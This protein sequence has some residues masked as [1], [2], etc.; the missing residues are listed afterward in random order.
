MTKNKELNNSHVENHTK[1]MF[2]SDLEE[3]EEHV[4]LNIEINSDIEKS[5]DDLDDTN[6]EPNTYESDK[7][8]CSKITEELNKDNVDPL[9]TTDCNDSKIND[10]SREGLS[11]EEDKTERIN[12]SSD[13]EIIENDQPK[14]EDTTS[15]QNNTNL[16]NAKHEVSEINHQKQST[17]KDDSEHLENELTPIEHEKQKIFSKKIEDENK[18]ETVEIDRNE[19][20]NERDKC[21]EKLGNET[22]KKEEKSDN[23][24]A[25]TE[26]KDLKDTVEQTTNNQQALD[27]GEERREENDDSIEELKDNSDKMM[28]EKELKSKLQENPSCPLLMETLTRKNDKET[29]NDDEDMDEADFDPSLL[30]PHISMEVDEDPVITTNGKFIINYYTY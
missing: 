27:N 25:G 3:E 6:E 13:I 11:D 20:K 19:V 15:N 16:E 22:E 10:E 12:I 5:D 26:A 1:E 28:K 8:E 4:P 24:S 7:E 18:P 9:D 30:C 23:K 21:E 2:D 29:P 17:E 14:H